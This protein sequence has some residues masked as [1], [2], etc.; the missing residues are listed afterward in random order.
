MCA[1][2]TV[3]NCESIIDIKSLKNNSEHFENSIDEH[4]ML[5]NGSCCT[6][7][8]YKKHNYLFLTYLKCNVTLL[9]SQKV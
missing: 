5:I 6:K 9:H 4:T 7:R 2:L 3:C 1:G 8:D